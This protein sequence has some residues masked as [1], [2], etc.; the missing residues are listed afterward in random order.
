MIVLYFI[1]R[2]TQR[3]HYYKSLDCFEYPK[4]PHSRK[5]KNQKKPSVML[6]DNLPY[7]FQVLFVL[8]HFN[9]QD[10]YA[11]LALKMNFVLKEQGLTYSIKILM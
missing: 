4:K 7:V 3:K 5:L 9:L 2:T 11:I 6:S 10:I 1:S 8:A